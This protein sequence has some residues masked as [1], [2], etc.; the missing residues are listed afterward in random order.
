MKKSL[1][2][3]TEKIFGIS[4]PAAF[5]AEKSSRVIDGSNFELKDFSGTDWQVQEDDDTLEYDPLQ[6]KAGR[7]SENNRRE[8]TGFCFLGAGNPALEKQRRVHKAKDRLE[9][10]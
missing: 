5:L 1:V 6:I 2:A 9:K 3:A 8:K 7:R 4:R 10:E